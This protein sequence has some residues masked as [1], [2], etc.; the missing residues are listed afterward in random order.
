MKMC[1][2]ATWTAL[3]IL[4]TSFQPTLAQEAIQYAGAPAHL[5][6]A[7]V[8]D[9]TVEVTLAPLGAN[10]IPLPTPESDVLVAYPREV[11]WEGDTLPS[12]ETPI[13]L[14][15]G[16]L[17][18]ELS[19]SPLALA[20]RKADG[21]LVQRFTWPEVEASVSSGL[22]SPGA[23]HFGTPAPVFGFGEGGGQYDRRGHLHSLRDGNA[24]FRRATHG[25]YIAVP[26]LIG[27][28]GWQLFVHHPMS[29]ENEFDMRGGEE[30]I[31]RPGE[32]VRQT[33]LRMLVTAWDNP[34]QIFTEYAAYAGA[35]ALPPRWALGYMQS[36]RTLSGPDEI[37][38]VARELRTRKLPTDALIYLGTGFTPTGWNH[39]HGLFDFNDVVFP[40]PAE[41][42][43]ELQEQDFKVTLHVYS[44]PR[45]LHGNIVQSPP[46]GDSAHMG[47]YWDLHRPA[48][49]NVGVDAW[50]PDG[51]ENLSSESRVAR[52]RMY[53]EG[54]LD[55]R[56]GLRPWSLH[57]TGYSGVHRYGGW[58]WSGDPDSRWS[59][60][61]QHIGVGL[62]HSVSLTP[63]WGSDIAG[64]VPTDEFTGDLYTRWLQFAAFTPSFRGH[65]RVWHLRLPFGWNRG[66]IG[67]PE[68]SI[69]DGPGYPYPE[70]LRN[71]LVEPIAREYLHLRYRLLP[72]NYTLTRE[73]H[74]SGLPLMRP[75]WIHYPDDPQAV[76]LDD[77]YL[78]GRHILVAPVYTKGA[79]QRSVYLPEGEWYD[80][81]TLERHTGGQSLSRQVDL[82]TLP[83]FVGAGAMI[84]LDPIRQFTEE[85]VDEPTTLRIFPGADGEYRW[86]RDDGESLDFQGGAYSWTRFTWDD[87]NHELT[88]EKDPEGGGGD[89]PPTVLRVQLMP[90]GNEVT[91]EWSGERTVVELR[92]LR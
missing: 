84:P 57:R 18:L 72:Y 61:R 49:E 8:T 43:R 27:T 75:L 16:A 74:D 89:P 65:G 64:F 11:I 46:P 7:R 12:G 29:R 90:Q 24:A 77:Q 37:R 1:P 39:G 2:R 23:M 20:V 60:L 47:N 14:S 44:P 63:F 52:H 55:S 78:W 54:S 21:T 17:V 69:F 36:H 91:V 40:R 26:R 85:V 41:I 42:V 79:S 31:F 73:A 51:G 80:W 33:P 56:P 34:T 25:A 68:S 9:R 53:R 45:G 38:W 28:E 70:E 6:L 4:T 59:T 22:R 13:S 92:G 86:Y 48:M 32:N 87:V 5:T 76:S 10:G 19:G 30:A 66:T 82:A 3:A 88:I 71:A 81:W 62:N 35:A 58:I 50:W 15:S 83:L 67:P